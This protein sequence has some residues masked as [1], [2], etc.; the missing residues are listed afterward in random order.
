MIIR[1]WIILFGLRAYL[2]FTY[3]TAAYNGTPGIDAMVNIELNFFVYQASQVF[4]V[5]VSQ[6]QRALGRWEQYRSFRQSGHWLGKLKTKSMLFNCRATLTSTNVSTPNYQNRSCYF[7]TI[8]FFFHF[9]G[10]MN[11][12]MAWRYVLIALKYSVE[13][14]TQNIILNRNMDVSTMIITIPKSLYVW[15][16]IHHWS[17]LVSCTN[18]GT[19]LTNSSYTVITSQ[20]PF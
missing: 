4:V 8:D 7:H 15:L 19:Q 2:F 9:S 1:D 13:Q 11:K 17:T 6:K 16:L 10:V 3:Y 20:K 14:T 12:T 5:L 18:V